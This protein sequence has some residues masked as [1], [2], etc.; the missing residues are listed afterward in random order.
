MNKNIKNP[1]LK[2]SYKDMNLYI[3]ILYNGIEKNAPSAPSNS[4]TS[5]EIRNSIKMIFGEGFFV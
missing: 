2:I 5:E 3:F 4:L 1:I